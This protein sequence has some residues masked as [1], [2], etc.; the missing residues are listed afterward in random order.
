MNRNNHTT[1]NNHTTRRFTLTTAGLAGLTLGAHASA[2]LV[3]FTV[4][5]D[6]YI[7]ENSWQVVNS[8]GSTVASMFI[9]GTYIYVGTSQSSTY[10]VSFNPWDSLGFE[11]TG[12]RTTFTMDLEQGNYDIFMQDSWGDGWVWSEATG[13]DAFAVSGAIEGGSATFAFTTGNSAVGAFTVVPTP[14]VL[15]LLGLGGLA[16]RGRRH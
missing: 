5:Q 2:E 9:D 6:R 11:V 10:P 8:A 3:N 15:A 12:Y 16:A 1:H 13:L 4:H 14:G 7:G